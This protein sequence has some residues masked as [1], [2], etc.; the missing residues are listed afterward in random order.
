MTD[1]Y[2]DVLLHFPDANG[3]IGDG[4]T[5]QAQVSQASCHPLASG[6]LCLTVLNT[7]PKSILLGSVC[8]RDSRGRGVCKRKRHT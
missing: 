7:H 5:T 8:H 4:V 6:V 2:L 3:P 1:S